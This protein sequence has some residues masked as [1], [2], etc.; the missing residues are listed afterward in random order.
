MYT[1][2]SMRR[3]ALTGLVGLAL[4]LG[5]DSTPRGRDASA[6]LSLRVAEI[7]VVVDAPSTGAPAISVLAFRA[8]V[9][10]L[11]AMDVLGVVNPLFGNAPEGKCELREVAGAARG[12]GALGGTVDLEEMPNVAVEL[13]GSIPILRP[14]P[15]VYPPLAPAVGGVI[16]EV[17][18]VDVVSPLPQAL[19]VTLPGADGDQRVAIDLPAL[20]RLLDVASNVLATGSRLDATGDLQLVV[21]RGSPRSFLEIRPLFGASLTMAC[22][23]GPAGR[24]VVPREL[25][26]RL[27]AS[28]G[29]VPLSFEAV[30]RES[31]PLLGQNTRLSVE[32]RSAAVLDLRATGGVSEAAR[33]PSSTSQ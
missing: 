5:C 21:D 28:S 23:V 26:G 2:L 9:T 15:R 18:P 22:P 11:P 19:V 24:V 8:H 20:P 31:R 32:A 4:G 33:A 13:G 17:G 27:T 14:F 12:L 30:S 25:L 16:G 3:S 10:G 1:S 7:A 6:P 29:R